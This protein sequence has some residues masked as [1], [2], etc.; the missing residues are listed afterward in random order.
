MGCYV[1]MFSLGIHTHNWTEWLRAN[2]SWLHYEE[3]YRYCGGCGDKEYQLL[4]L[5]C[6]TK[7]RTGEYCYWCKGYALQWEAHFD[8][9]QVLCD[10]ELMKEKRPRPGMPAKVERNL[11][12]YQLRNE[13]WSMPEL[14]RKYKIGLPTVSDILTRLAIQERRGSLKG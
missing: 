11:E 2:H 9:I 14:A 8:K 6:P 7:K 5:V 1:F 12:M 3:I 4:S 13:G 10:N